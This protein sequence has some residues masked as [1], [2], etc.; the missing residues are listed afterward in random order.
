MAFLLGNH[1]VDYYQLS[2]ELFELASMALLANGNVQ[3][4]CILS[5]D[6][7]QNSP[8]FEDKLNIYF[9]VISLLAYASEIS[10]VLKKGC[11]IVEQLGEIFPSDP[12]EE[13]TLVQHLIEQAH[14]GND[15][16]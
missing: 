2:L 14:Q 12:S 13:D 16:S 4:T 15:Q 1:W 10:E 3:Y 5:D 6:V 7:L 8:C 9:T 11:V